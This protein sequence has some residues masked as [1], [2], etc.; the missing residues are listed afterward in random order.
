MH[1]RRLYCRAIGHYEMRH[2]G[3]LLQLTD[4]DTRMTVEEFIA[5]VTRAAHDLPDPAPLHLR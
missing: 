2:N 1:A 5:K 4:E 3:N